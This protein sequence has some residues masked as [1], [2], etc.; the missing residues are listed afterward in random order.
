M[1]TQQAQKALADAGLR[2][3]SKV[4]EEPSDDV[5]E[6]H[7][8]EQTHPSGSQVSKGTEVGITVSTGPGG[9]PGAAGHRA[10]RG[11]TRCRTWRTPGSR[12]TCRWWTPPRT[13]TG[14]CPPPI[15]GTTQP[16]GT[17]V[18][19]EVSRG[20]QFTMPQLVGK[21]YDEVYSALQQAGWRGGPDR[22][23][24]TNVNQLDPLAV[25]RVVGQSA[26]EG[27]TIDRNAPITVRVNALGIP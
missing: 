22:V 10:D 17:T 14:C 4:S 18:T 24:R 3:R 20:N 16:R 13:R 21:D 15:E 8:I 23:S 11:T 7:V 6:G 19:I 27:E 12:W 1:T 2:L 9:D 26:R 25:D 5:E